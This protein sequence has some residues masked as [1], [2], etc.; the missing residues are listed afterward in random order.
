[1]LLNACCRSFVALLR[2]S[3][4]CHQLLRSSRAVRRAQ[5]SAVDQLCR[6]ICAAVIAGHR[7]SGAGKTRLFP[8]FVFGS[9]PTGVTATSPSTSRSQ[10]GSVFAQVCWVAACLW[11]NCFLSLQPYPSTRAFGSQTSPY[12]ANASSCPSQTARFWHQ[13]CVRAFQVRNDVTRY[14]YGDEQHLEE[15]LKRIFRYGQVRRTENTP[16]V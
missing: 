7:N 3:Y 14:R 9:H 5:A 13:C 8:V 1:M 16:F 12:S 10:S 15:A 2:L 4:T 6:R 11:L